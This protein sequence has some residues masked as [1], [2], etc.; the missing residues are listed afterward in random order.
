M[1]ST[2]FGELPFVAVTGAVAALSLGVV[3]LGLFLHLGVWSLVLLVIPGAIVA[4]YIGQYAKL[5]PS[6]PVASG[7]DLTGPDE[8]FDDPVEEADRMEI[9]ERARRAQAS[10]DDSPAPPEPAGSDSEPSLPELES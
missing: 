10:S 7:A 4:V 2:G 5:H 3:A 8:P 9:E 6:E 1:A